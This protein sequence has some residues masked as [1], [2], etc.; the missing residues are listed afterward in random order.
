MCNRGGGGG[1]VGSGVVV[2]RGG[3]GSLGA[4]TAF[5]RADS[6]TFPQ[7]TLPN[8]QMNI[9]I[10]SCFFGMI[11]TEPRGHKKTCAHDERT[12]FMCKIFS[13]PQNIT[14][15]KQAFSISDDGAVC[16][17]G[18]RFLVDE[19]RVSVN[20]VMVH[21]SI[22]VPPPPCY[23]EAIFT[24]RRGLIVHCHFCYWP[25]PEWNT[26]KFS[27]YLCFLMASF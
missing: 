25:L 11:F 16:V 18:V 4:E 21:P 8:Y 26:L 1:G 17:E 9:L 5:A 14:P 6:P 10:D 20:D 15:Y 24:P 23:S 22:V 19:L 7:I 3:V 2:G 13:P 27:P 12:W